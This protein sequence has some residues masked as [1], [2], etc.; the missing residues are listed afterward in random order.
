MSVTLAEPIEATLPPPQVGPTVPWWA[1]SRADKLIASVITADRGLI[2]TVK[3]LAMPVIKRARRKPQA[4][5]RQTDITDLARNWRNQLDGS[6]RL[7]LVIDFDPDKRGI[8]IT[9]CRVTVL[10]FNLSDWPENHLE[11]GLSLI[12]IRF[13]V[14]PHDFSLTAERLAFISHHALGRRF[15]RGIGQGDTDVIADLANLVVDHD[16]LITHQPFVCRTKSGVWA[17]EPNV[18]YG[19]PET[20]LA[21]RTFM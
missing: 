2:T 6:T 17:G 19:R 14:A 8:L 16:Q 10:E 12:L 5:I 15:Q 21:V 7:G 20:V 1:Q 9:D 11:E 13:H 18:L 3:R 4:P